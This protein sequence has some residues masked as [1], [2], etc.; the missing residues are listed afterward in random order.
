MKYEYTIFAK[1]N[2]DEEELQAKLAQAGLVEIFVEKYINIENLLRDQNNFLDEN[3]DSKWAKIRSSGIIK[4]EEMIEQIEKIIR[5]AE[6]KSMY[7]LMR[8][9]YDA[10]V[11]CNVPNA[12]IGVMMSR[13][14]ELINQ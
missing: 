4:R 1:G 7:T 11:A 2:L 8:S 6:C 14:L 13:S 12:M 5:D 10:G 9:I 3:F